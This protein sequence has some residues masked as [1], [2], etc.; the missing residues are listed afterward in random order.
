MEVSRVQ[1]VQVCA[2]SIDQLEI[3]LAFIRDFNFENRT[4]IGQGRQLRKNFKNHKNGTFG[5]CLAQ[6]STFSM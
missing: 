4:I 3:L 6:N 2:H 1:G 5:K